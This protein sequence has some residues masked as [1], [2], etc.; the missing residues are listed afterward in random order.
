MLFGTVAVAVVVFEIKRKHRRRELSA[1][2]ELLFDLGDAV[3]C[4][5]QENAVGFVLR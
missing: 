1:K 4:A 5:L 3:K 2:G